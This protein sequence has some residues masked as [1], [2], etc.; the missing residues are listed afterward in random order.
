MSIK[1][2]I[3]K[4][5]EEQRWTLG[6]I[7]EPVEDILAGKPYKIN[8]IKGQPNDRWFA[9]PF[10]LDY[11]KETITVLVE[12]YLY[13]TCIGRIAKLT[14]D[15]RTYEIITN[16]LVLELDS[17]LSFPAI[18]RKTHKI[19]LYPENAKGYGL[20]LYEYDSLA[21]SCKYVKTISKEPLAD[22]IIT[23]LWE[24]EFM[25]STHM[26]TH[27]GDTL[28]VYK[29]GEDHP[30]FVSSYRFPSNIARNAGD[31]FK[32]R[33]DKYR[34]AQDCNGGYGKAVLLQKVTRKGVAFCFE[35][36]RRIKSS[37]PSY[38][39]GCHT[40]N[41]FNGLSV[42]DVHGYKHNFA[43]KLYEKYLSLMK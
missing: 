40:F 20:A 27:N 35:N 25:F 2:F 34:P 29:L 33:E 41:I 5:C 1:S 11:N 26:P 19:Y 10:I 8:Y 24:D 18:K 37:H 23:D 4:I 6:F 15:R 3:K 38:T 32:V 28:S 43:G 42:I 14:I 16:N 39:T 21:N 17:H 30:V 36:I 9:D 13:K 7:E 12:E 31:W 22:A